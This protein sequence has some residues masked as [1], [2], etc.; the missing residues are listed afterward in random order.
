[1]DPLSTTS[2][3]PTFTKGAKGA[4]PHSVSSAGDAEMQL[5]IPAGYPFG[6]P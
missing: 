3:S 5:A 2:S 6:H 4:L 1:M